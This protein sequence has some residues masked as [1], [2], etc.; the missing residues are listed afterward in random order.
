MAPS[1]DWIGTRS[2]EE[3]LSSLLDNGLLDL[4]LWNGF[5]DILNGLQEL[6]LV[7]GLI[8]LFSIMYSVDDSSS[9]CL[10]SYSSH[11]LL[12]TLLP[13]SW[14]SNLIFVD[15]SDMGDSLLHFFGLG[16]G[17]YI[18]TLFLFNSN[19]FDTSLKFSEQGWLSSS[20]SLFN[21]ES[22]SESSS[23]DSSTIS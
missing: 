19:V 21:S 3:A 12:S 13:F 8:S 5:L 11:G 15:G 17:P 16:E 22:L 18:G 9:N 14:W 4:E 23:S 20:L 6:L 7:S 2:F 10:G 1:L